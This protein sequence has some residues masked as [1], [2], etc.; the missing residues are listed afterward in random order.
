M[1]GQV[2]LLLCQARS[3]THL[4]W[5]HVLRGTRGTAPPSRTLCLQVICWEL[6]TEQRF[7]GTSVG[8]AAVL[9]IMLGHTPLPTE[10]AIPP[11]TRKRL[12]NARF[13]KVLLSML[14]REPSSRPNVK[15]VLARWAAIFYEDETEEAK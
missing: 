4:S 5:L 10:Q 12:G 3:A 11:E 9:N 13:Q 6:L 2:P 7:L 1:D 8:K 15:Q 14:E